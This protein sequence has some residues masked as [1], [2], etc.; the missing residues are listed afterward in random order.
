MKK[1][2]YSL[3]GLLMMFSL[4]NS[5]Y[6]NEEFTLRLDGP[7]E[8]SYYIDLDVV[9]DS[10]TGFNN[11]LSGI[12]ANIVYDDTKLILLS[13]NNIG[14]F[15]TFFYRKES[16]VFEAVSS[17]EMPIGSK[18]ARIRFRNRNLVDH[19][20]TTFTLNNITGSNGDHDIEGKCLT[21][22]V[23]FIRPN[24]QKGDMNKS[25]DI[26]LEDIIILLKVYLSGHPTNEELEIG[27]LSANG[28]INIADVIMLLKIYLGS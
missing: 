3:I 7:I 25:G 1:V 27:D 5:V 20:I 4:N 13:V 10:F 16:T 22:S 19:E 21:K 24:Y 28:S 2:L 26:E 23:T 8:F 17:M 15:D 18:V 6:A 14:S 11:G 9:I 12:D